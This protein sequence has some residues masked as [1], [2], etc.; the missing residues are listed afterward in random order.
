[1]ENMTYRELLGVLIQMDEK[2]LDN[3]VSIYV[4]QID[5][6]LP[7]QNDGVQIALGSDVLNDG[8]LFIVV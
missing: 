4:Q 8:H 6:F 3:N 5:E 7:V 1:M 2:Q